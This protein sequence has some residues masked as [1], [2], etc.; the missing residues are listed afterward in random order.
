[1]EK[2]LSRV[3]RKITPSE[4][5]REKFLGVLKKIEKIADEIIKP[6]GL[7]K[8]VAGSFIRDTWLAD[9]RE[10]DLFIL[11]PVSFSREKLEKI[12]LK[13]GMGITEGLGGKYEIAYAEHPY[14]KG[15]IGDFKID[16]VPCY[17]VDSASKIKSAVD[18]TPF[19]NR[20]IMKN[21]K[22]YMA[23]EVRLLKQFCKA[24]DVYGS[25]IRTQGFSGYLCELLVIRY[26]TF[27]NIIRSAAKWESGVFI[28]LKNHCK[29]KCPK[30]HFTGQPLI[31]IDP[32]DPRRN[33][34]ASL[35]NENFIKFVETC[36]RFLRKPSVSFFEIKGKIIKPEELKRHLK[37]RKTNLLVLEFKR[38]AVVD[39]ILWSQLRK[40]AARV[41]KLLKANDF[42]I[43][44]WMV[45]SDEE[46]SYMIFE[47]KTWLLSS[48]KKLTGPPASSKRHSD[49]FRSKYAGRKL[50]I[51]DGKWV[52]TA[53]RKYTK[54]EYLISDFLKRNEKNLLNDG[55]RSHIA[56]GIVSGFKILGKNQ[57]ETLIK[58]N[59]GFSI[60][61][62]KYFERKV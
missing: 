51:E 17:K 22:P 42:E 28:D 50:Y 24:M 38:P 39:D 21:L 11:F 57:L 56:K 19:H 10:M 54:A 23:N 9:K 35:S 16:I 44:E 29:I 12:G 61:M 60:F 45:W 53:K 47:M 43:F 59:T 37:T 33:V 34:A 18:R 36:K 48:L 62:R 46:N 30:E 31:V 15:V 55:I 5:E 27:K 20:Y 49:E 32:T 58:N 3:L 1:M 8:T 13:I 6:L 40:T 41:V 14:V 4:N 26:K 25:D 7:E 2:V 52:T